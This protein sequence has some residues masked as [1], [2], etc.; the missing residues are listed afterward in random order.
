MEWLKKILEAA[1][2]KDGKLDVDTLIASIGKEVPKHFVPKED[3]NS[4]V[5]ELKTA[6][7]TIKNLKDSNRDNETLQDTIKKHEA[8]IKNLQ[9]DN[10]NTKKEYALKD[11]LTKE[12]CTDPA[13]F[14]YKQGGLDKFSFD[15]DGAPV[16]VKEMVE[17]LKA[18]NP[19]LFP[20]GG[21]ETHYNPT[22]GG[23]SGKNPFD[24]DS[25]NLTEQGKLF[26][27]NPEQARALA[28]AAGVEI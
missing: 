6:N 20:K 12:G 10:E 1:E 25:F 13:Y 21:K 9:K 7:D 14:I 18:D 3:F 26:R 27:E 11:A 16:G 24:K 22:G 19:I 2:I 17:P 23:T 15:K 28:A 5:S 8:T 4:K